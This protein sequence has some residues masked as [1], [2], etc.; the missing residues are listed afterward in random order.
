MTTHPAWLTDLLS[1]HHALR[2]SGTEQVVCWC[3]WKPETRLY[4][5]T[6]WD[7]VRAHVAAVV[8]S[9]IE[10]RTKA[11]TMHPLDAEFLLTEALGDAHE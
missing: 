8:W 11:A 3:L 6:E 4:G 9:E 7:A 1:E 5:M 10:R 2:D